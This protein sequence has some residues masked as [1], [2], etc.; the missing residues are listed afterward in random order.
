MKR[1]I[2]GVNLSLPAVGAPAAAASSMAMPSATFALNA[3][4]AFPILCT[5]VPLSA[6]THYILGPM[7][8]DAAFPTDGVSSRACVAAFVTRVSPHM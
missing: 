4:G 1:I 8:L 2:N 3:D 5:A 7:A 6:G